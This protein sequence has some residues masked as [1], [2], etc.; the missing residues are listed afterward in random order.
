MSALLTSKDR[1]TAIQGYAGV[2]KTSMLAE[3]ALLINAQGY[4]MR[5]VTVASSAAFE[6]QEKAGIKTDVFPLVHQELKAAPTAS[7]SKTLFIVDEASMLSSHQGH[8]LIKHIERTGARLLL[9]GDTAQLPSVNAGRLFGLTQE[10]GIKTTVMDE[11]VRQKNETLK[12]AV[13][14]A[15]QGQVSA[16]IDKLDVKALATHDERVAWIANHW[17]ALTPIKREKTL[18]FAPTHANRESITQLLRQGLKQEGTLEGKPYNQ[19]I[20]KAKAMEPIQQR[21]VAYFQ[22]N[23]T[24]RFNQ[25]FKKNK[26]K[27]GHYYTVG[28]I[29]K[30]NRD[31]NVLP[32]IDEQGKLIKF[33]L[34]ELPQYKTHTAP[35]ERPLEVYEPKKLELLPNDKVMWTR[36][37]KSDAI[38]NGQCATLKDIKEDIF[39]FITKEGQQLALEKSHPALNHLDYSYVLTNYKVQGKDAPFGVG[40]MESVHRFGSTLNNFYVQISRA[41]HGMTLV[42]DNKEKLINAIRQNTTEKPAALDMTTSTQLMRHEQG[43]HDKNE[44]S[45]QAVIT[46]KIEL[47]SLELTDCKRSAMNH[48][49]LLIKREVSDISKDFSKE[50]EL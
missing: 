24:L 27:A 12:E 10:Y 8:E 43:F 39:Y 2:A 41:V 28:E 11:I 18:L 13:M 30:K 37:F 22:K 44:H 14:A 9:V 35:F 26:I 47:E 32:L 7:L 20:L 40:L 42:T 50:L 48:D 33:N 25:D 45:L 15:T 34:R 19:T 6:L 5:G 29:S 21:F 4:E 38:R 31:N 1:Y 36:N 3:A 16:A 17:L 23:D 46:K 49:S